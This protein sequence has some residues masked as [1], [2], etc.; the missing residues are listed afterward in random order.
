MCVYCEEI[1]H[2][3][4]L[5]CFSTKANFCPNCGRNMQGGAMSGF[6]R[7][8]AMKGLEEWDNADQIKKIEEEVD[9]AKEAYFG[10]TG[11]LPYGLEL[12]D[13]IQAAETALRIN[14]GEDE[15]EHLRQLTIE[16]NRKRGYYGEE[17]G[18]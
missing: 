9:E 15:V 1:L 12:M 17:D 4:K 10:S 18:E 2:G 6:Y 14:F 7:F 3:G 11:E 8:P 5:V 13:V 16:K